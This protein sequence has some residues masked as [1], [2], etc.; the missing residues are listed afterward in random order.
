MKQFCLYLIFIFLATPVF[1]S[2]KSNNNNNIQE[3]NVIEEVRPPNIVQR[4]I[5]LFSRISGKF[6]KVSL[7]PLVNIKKIAEKNAFLNVY[8]S[9]KLNKKA[10]SW[11]HFSLKDNVYTEAIRSD[12]QSENVLK[13]KENKKKWGL[14]KV[15]HRPFTVTP[16]KSKTYKNLSIMKT[17]PNENC[18]V[19]SINDPHDFIIEN[20][21]ININNCFFHTDG[22]FILRGDKIITRCLN[23]DSDLPGYTFLRS[24]NCIRL[25]PFTPGT[26]YIKCITFWPADS[27]LASWLE[28]EFD[29]PKNELNFEILN[30]DRVV[31]EF[32]DNNNKNIPNLNNK[33][34]L[35]NSALN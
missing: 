29:F 7:T 31:I 9:S 4:S 32:T 13:L 33:R 8:T 30:V 1:S 12:F 3:E 15:D 21:R 26:S 10:S 6:E 27:Q 17:V 19:I 18:S 34:K 16:I 2:N 24:R 22:Q 11:I 28:G 35:R 14:N 5:G 20:S 23:N 25:E